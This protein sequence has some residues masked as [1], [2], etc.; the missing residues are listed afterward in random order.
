MKAG[1]SVPG[2]EK[3]KAVRQ[4]VQKDVL[5]FVA[6]SVKSSREEEGNVKGRP[7]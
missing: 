7:Q 2:T 4:L 1:D 5:V 6:V 3:V